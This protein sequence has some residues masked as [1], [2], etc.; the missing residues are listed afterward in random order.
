MPRATSSTTRRNPVRP[1]SRICASVRADSLQLPDRG[2]QR[3]LYRLPPAA[4]SR[5]RRDAVPGRAGA[6]FLVNT[7]IAPEA[8]WDQLPAELQQQASDKQLRLF[9]ASMPTRWP[10]TAVW[11][12]ASTRSCRPASL[13]S[14]AC[15]RGS[16]PS[17]RSRP[18]SRKAMA[19][20]AGASSRS[21]LPPSTRPSMGCTRFRSVCP[22][23]DSRAV[24][25]N[26]GRRQ[27]YR[28]R[29]PAHHGR[30]GRLDPGQ[31]PARG[32]QFPHGYR[33]PREAQPG[34]GDSGL[35]RGPVHPVRQMRAGLPACGDTRKGVP[36]GLA[37]ARRIP[38]RP[39]PRAA[40]T[41]RRL[42]V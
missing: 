14:P 26:R 31:R 37:E 15:C 35:G 4:V 30:R 6:V 21:T 25:R 18:R 12:S 9:T 40:R 28:S 11:A 3:E 7:P 20:A 33:R 8:F 2:R 38:S 13:R 29:Y 32:R 41:T 10:R 1:R 24:R 34:A 16:R 19:A 36:R 27:L 5:Q 17:M 42:P 23:T 22:P 39:C